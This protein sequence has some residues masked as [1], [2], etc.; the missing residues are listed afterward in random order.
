[1][2]GKLWSALDG[3]KTFLGYLGIQAFDDNIIHTLTEAFTAWGDAISSGEY[4]QV[5]EP[6]ARAVAQI[7][8]F[9]GVSHK[10]VK[11]LNKD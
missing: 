5:L 3:K 2:D 1:M 6:T 4:V 8:L 10:A 7:L 11:A 9:L